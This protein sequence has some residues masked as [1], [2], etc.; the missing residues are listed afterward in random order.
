MG[1]KGSKR[2]GKRQF[3]VSTETT[4]GDARISE[5]RGTAAASAKRP[6][7]ANQVSDDPFADIHR[8]A[9]P[10]SELGAVDAP[11]MDML[12][13][14]I[15]IRADTATGMVYPTAARLLACLDNLS[16]E[17]SAAVAER[18]FAWLV[19]PVSA[20]RFKSQFWDR[21]CVLLRRDPT[22]YASLCS[23]GELRRLLSE[24]P[25]KYGE[26]IDVTS[27]RVA[28]GRRTLNSAG[29][30][31]SQTVWQAFELEGWC[32]RFVRPH[33]QLRRLWQ[34]MSQFEEYFGCGVAL[35]VYVTPQPK[36][37][38]KNQGFAPQFSGVDIFMMQVSGSQRLRLYT[39]P[40]ADAMWPRSA[41]GDLHSSTIGDPFLDV[42]LSPGALLYIPR[43]IVFQACTEYGGDDS[44]S[45]ELRLSTSPSTTY[46]DLLAIAL[47]RALELATAE[48]PALRQHL[49]NDYL[50]YMGVC[51]SNHVD[52]ENKIQ[53]SNMRLPVGVHPALRDARAEL[54]D[55]TLA[56]ARAQ[57]KK[58]FVAHVHA[59]AA[60]VVN[61]WL[62]LDSAADQMAKKQLLEERLP[63]AYSEQQRACCILGVSANHSTTA[64]GGS[65]SQLEKT[66]PLLG[67]D[68]LIRLATRQS[69]RLCIEGEDSVTLYHCLDNATEGTIQFA[70]RPLYQERGVLFS[71]EFAPALEFIIGAYPQYVQVQSLPEV[72][73]VEEAVELAGTLFELGVVHLSEVATRAP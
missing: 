15:E 21:R 31:S 40:H 38:Q 5:L 60:K 46:H 29:V 41:S 19:Y 22:H 48:V 32:L 57:A 61:H 28:G 18:T 14:T 34:L 13:E 3:Q 58:R 72:E 25:L 47:P 44:P 65:E 50:R 67:P 53:P 36:P 11:N 16:T 49:P 62:P 59:L 30:A 37:G 52:G 39:P 54:E 35:N 42:V 45:L 66:A 17:D 56:T 55:S 70:G 8:S 12:R 9:P 7:A 51:F 64:V 4:A 43:G 63:P 71:M 10:L 24:C 23:V 20:M 6:K 2:R 26:H 33:D 73:G 27:Y 1:K 68:S 69:V